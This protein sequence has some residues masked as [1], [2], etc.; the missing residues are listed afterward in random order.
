MR[1]LFVADGHSPIARS[2]I[3]SVAALGHDVALLTTHPCD[4][5]PGDRVPI[6]EACIALAG[7]LRRGP[8]VHAA[9][10]RARGSLPRVLSRLMRGRLAM[11]LRGSRWRLAT[12]DLHR[13][14]ERCRR[15]IERFAPDL[16]HAMRITF[17]GALAA[18]ATPPRTP[19]LV[20]VWGNEFTLH[21]RSGAP[22]RRLIR[23][24]LERADG[25]FADCRRDARLARDDWGFEGSTLAVLPGA[26]GIDATQFRPGE[27]APDRRRALG[28]PE[29]ADVIVN[30][31]G[32]RR[33]V[34]NHEFYRALP[35]L[36]E[37]RPNLCVLAPG[38]ADSAQVR[39]WTRSLGIEDRVRRLP[40]VSPAEM[41]DLFRVA[42]V[43]VSPSLH[44][45]TPNTLLEAM[46]CG[47]LPVAGDLESVREW[48]LDG[49]N[50]LLCDP[51]DPAQIAAAI[52]RG[53]ED[54][55]LR[56][57]A[58]GRNL[59]LVYERA[60]RAAVMHRVDEL[61]DELATR[62]ASVR[63]RGERLALGW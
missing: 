3:E 55:A 2:W 63:E 6:V 38:T 28:I 39:D 51:R 59:R 43:T 14:R 18:L 26:G 25:L 17:E 56:E 52:L 36:L 34:C 30:P 7:L 24:T 45:G 49:V 46:A 23:K 1:I 29:D 58:R 35:A 15:E 8:A 40:V 13:Q 16:V 22:V 48:I 20:S 50:G 61:Y 57:R 37:R 54:G 33:Y 21:A 31:R 44:D 47:C 12:I 60:E 42:S 62:G 9:D 10:G 53:L 41:A 19:L 11:A 4:G 32:V 27:V 5:F